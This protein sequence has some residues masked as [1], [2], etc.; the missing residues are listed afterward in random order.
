LLD[1]RGGHG[2]GSYHGVK[3]DSGESPAHGRAPRARRNRSHREGCTA[4]AVAAAD[5]ESS[6]VYD[7]FIANPL[8]ADGQPL[9]SAVHK[10]MM[11]A[12]ALDAATLVT[13]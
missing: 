11:P 6:V 4:L 2:R 5:T 1:G 12:A 13:A 8:M 3:S 9:F 10:N 7:L